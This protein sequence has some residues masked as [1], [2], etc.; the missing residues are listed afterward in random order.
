MSENTR[1]A[2]AGNVLSSALASLRTLGFVVTV[3]SD[4]QLLRAEGPSCTLI[5]EDPLALLGLAKLYE[6]RGSEWRPT[7]EELEAFLAFE[8]QVGERPAP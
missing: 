2:S 3:A 6:L 1:I 5:A 7:D 8:A 4:S